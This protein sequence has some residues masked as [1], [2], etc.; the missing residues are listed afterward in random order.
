M[1]IKTGPD[2]T[3]DEALVLSSTK[4]KSEVAQAN[5]CTC[6]SQTFGLGLGSIA[7]VLNHSKIPVTVYDYKDMYAPN[8][9]QQLARPSSKKYDD[10]RLRGAGIEIEQRQYD[11]ETSKPLTYIETAPDKS[12]AR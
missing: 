9:S 1:Y 6:E 11:E 2:G 12:I 7:N 3:I 4:S 5:F 10:P 8:R